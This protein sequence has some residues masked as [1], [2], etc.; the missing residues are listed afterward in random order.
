MSWSEALG[1]EKEDNLLNR[2]KE[3]ASCITNLKQDSLAVVKKDLQNASIAHNF[4]KMDRDRANMDRLPPVDV[5][6][7]GI[8]QCMVDLHNLCDTAKGCQ[9]TDWST[10]YA[11][12]VMV[13]G[14][15][16]A[17]SYSGRTHHP[18][19]PPRIDHLVLVWFESTFQL[20][21]LV[22]WNYIRSRKTEGPL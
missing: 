16:I 10:A 11:S 2:W 8:T 19:L 20:S 3:A 17:N 9:G 1:K 14:F 21:D 18:E 15:T 7:E 4:R 13:M 12:N 6:K 22:H 5:L